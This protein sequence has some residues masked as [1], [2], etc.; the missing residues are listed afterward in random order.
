MPAPNSGPLALHPI[1]DKNGPLIFSM[2]IRSL[3]GSTLA[4]SSR[5]FRAAASGSAYGRASASFI[6]RPDPLS[7]HVPRFVA[8]RLEEDA[9]GPWLHPKKRS[10]KSRLPP[11][12]SR[13]PASP[14]G[15]LHQPRHL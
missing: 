13:S 5:S 7:L 10:A 14:S 2:W 4:A 9:A 1:L 8:R 15:G 3:I 11:A 12:S 6:L